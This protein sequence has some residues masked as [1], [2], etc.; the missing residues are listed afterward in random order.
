MSGTET[1]R[2]D[3]LCSQQVADLLVWLV[4]HPPHDANQATQR[5]YEALA[6][7]TEELV[8]QLTGYLM[9][10]HA[11]RDGVFELADAVG[12]DATLLQYLPASHLV[13]ALGAL[14]S[15]IMKDVPGLRLYTAD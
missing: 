1:M 9:D 6:Q 4:S 5:H 13:H 14:Q 11:Q 10:F 15:D 12:A 2:A 8:V 3:E 7:H